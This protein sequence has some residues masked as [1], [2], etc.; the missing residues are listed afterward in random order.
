MLAPPVAK[1][2]H[3]TWIVLLDVSVRSYFD[4]SLIGPIAA[5]ETHFEVH[6]P[7][8]K[9]V[10]GFAI[11][12]YFQVHSNYSKILKI[13]KF[14]LSRRSILCLKCH[15]CQFENVC[16]DLRWVFH[17]PIHQSKQSAVADRKLKFGDFQKM[18][19][20][21]NI[22]KNH[23]FLGYFQKY[24]KYWKILIAKESEIELRSF[25]IYIYHFSGECDA[26]NIKPDYAF[27]GFTNQH[28][29]PSLLCILDSFLLWIRVHSIGRNQWSFI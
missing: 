17:V 23:V 1:V 15:H 14:Q 24:Q 22:S 16:G 20:I 6:F 19:K 12:Q 25:H 10:H 26:R 7:D 3:R 9:S 2:L 13:K 21:V 28:D 8:C 5:S 18:L 11:L 29:L 27:P 4:F